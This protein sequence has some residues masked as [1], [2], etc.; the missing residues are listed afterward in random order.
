M[1]EN[2]KKKK[3]KKKKKKNERIIPKAHTHI[4]TMTK[5]PAKFQKVWYKTV[6]GAAPTSYQCHPVT[7]KKKKQKKKK[8][9]KTKLTKKKKEKKKLKNDNG[10]TRNPKTTCT[11]SNHV[12]QLCIVSK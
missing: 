4:Q 6:R 5:T 11:F 12:E 9:K 1:G 2:E 10:R 7:Q 3:K 8:K